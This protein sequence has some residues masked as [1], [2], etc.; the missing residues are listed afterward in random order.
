MHIFCSSCVFTSLIHK[1]HFQRLKRKNPNLFKS[2]AKWHLWKPAAALT[3]T[4]TSVYSQSSVLAGQRGYLV[5]TLCANTPGAAFHNKRR[6][7]SNKTQA[8]ECMIWNTGQLKGRMRKTLQRQRGVGGLLDTGW[9]GPAGCE[10]EVPAG[11]R[12]GRWKG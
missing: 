7:T 12:R 10:Q 2:S 1:Q 8:S 3:N 5:A 4:E 6:R 9:A 11:V